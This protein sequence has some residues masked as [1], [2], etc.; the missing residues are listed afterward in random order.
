[1]ENQIIKELP[2][3]CHSSDRD[4]ASDSAPDQPLEVQSDH[5][6]ASAPDQPLQVQSD[7]EPASAPDQPL[8]VQSDHEPASV[9][10]Q[11]DHEPAEPKID[12]TPNVQENAEPEDDQPRQTPPKDTEAPEGS[13]GRRM[14]QA[15]PRSSIDINALKNEII[16]VGMQVR[17]FSYSSSS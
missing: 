17:N 6:P 15:W 7:H 2:S 10:W 16:T 3:D 13:E 12:T 9:V 1:M 8:Q 11:S 4:S 14:T 5:E